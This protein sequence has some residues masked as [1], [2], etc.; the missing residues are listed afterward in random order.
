MTKEDTKIKDLEPSKNVEDNVNKEKN[1]KKEKKKKENVNKSKSKNNSK[2]K[3]KRIQTFDSSD[4]EI[5]SEEEGT[6]RIFMYLYNYI[7]SVTSGE[8]QRTVSAMNKSLQQN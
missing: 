7:I 5:D 2:V 4:E 6:C 8:L 3:R 1:L